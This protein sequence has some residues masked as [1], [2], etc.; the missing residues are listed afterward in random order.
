MTQPMSWQNI[1]RQ[2]QALLE[3]YAQKKPYMLVVELGLPPGSHCVQ[4][5]AIE[6]GVLGLFY[7]PDKGVTPYLIDPDT[8]IALEVLPE[9][10]SVQSVNPE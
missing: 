2:N 3:R 5:I 6:R 7:I 4:L 1:S 9:V 10:G 8:G